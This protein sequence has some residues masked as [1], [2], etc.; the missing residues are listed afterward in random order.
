MT[1]MKTKG[2][3]VPKALAISRSVTIAR[4]VIP[5]RV[6]IRMKARKARIKSEKKR[7]KRR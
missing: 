6:L 5:K 7:M 4:T 2:V 1:S 3:F